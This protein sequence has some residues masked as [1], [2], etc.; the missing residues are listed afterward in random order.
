[1]TNGTGRFERAIQASQQLIA[2]E[3][4]VQIGYG[5]LAS[6]LFFLGRFPEAEGALR[7]AYERKLDAANDLLLRY[8][9]AVLQGDNGRMDQVVARA[10]SKPFTEH[11]VAHAEALALAR[12]GRLQAAR[13]SS[14]R[15][16]DLL[17]QEGAEAGE[18]AATYQAA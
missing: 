13:V 9:I 5:N 3:P 17:L 11:R 15:A 8:N 14:R 2:S 7:Q 10:K 4:G 12:S 18:Q 6:S 16:V 1:S